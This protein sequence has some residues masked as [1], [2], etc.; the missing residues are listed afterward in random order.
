MLALA[1]TQFRVLAITK[2]RSILCEL[3]NLAEVRRRDGQVIKKQTRLHLR[4]GAA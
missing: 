4:L 1:N 2:E 3:R